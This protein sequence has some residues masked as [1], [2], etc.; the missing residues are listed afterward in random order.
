MKAMESI[1]D[2]RVFA[3]QQDNTPATAT[4]V[5]TPEKEETNLLKR[6]YTSQQSA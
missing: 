4:A 3:S 6:H 2:P 1:D 5:I